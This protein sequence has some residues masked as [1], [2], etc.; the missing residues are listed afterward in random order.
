MLGTYFNSR[1]ISKAIFTSFEFIDAEFQKN[2]TKIHH[3][4]PYF[5]H[6][7]FYKNKTSLVN[8]SHSFQGNIRNEP[9]WWK[10][11]LPSVLNAFIALFINTTRRTI[12]RCLKCLFAIDIALIGSKLTTRVANNTNIIIY[13]F[14]VLG[15]QENLIC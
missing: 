9:E 5:G 15:V 6:Y 3:W 1:M 11:L 14:N 7:S 2:A 12:Q 8:L 13:N 10:L 4:W